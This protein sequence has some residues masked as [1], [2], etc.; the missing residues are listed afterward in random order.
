[1]HRFEEDP[2]VPALGAPPGAAGPEDVQHRR[3]ILLCHPRQHGRL[4]P[5]RPAK[6]HRSTNVG[7]HSPHTQPNPST[8]PSEAE[9]VG[10]RLFARVYKRSAGQV[11]CRVA[12]PDHGPAALNL[13]CNGLDHL[14]LPEGATV[15]TLEQPWVRLDL[16]VDGE[17]DARVITK[18]GVNLCAF[19]YGADFVRQPAFKN[20]VDFVRYATGLGPQLI[21]TETWKCISEMLSQ[22]R[23]H[24]H[25]LL[26]WPLPNPSG[27]TL[28]FVATLYGIPCLPMLLAQFMHDERAPD[29]PT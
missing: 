12:N 3:P 23:E 29:A 27:V 1:M 26:L 22:K 13:V 24:E 21:D 15:E 5:N 6:C 4:L 9:E 18:I 10:A 16:P 2:V 28:V 17:V 19:W 20:A 11:V 8:R 7:I 14:N 25:A